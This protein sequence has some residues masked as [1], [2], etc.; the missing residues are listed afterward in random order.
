[1]FC[2]KCGTENPDNARLCQSCSWDLTNISTNAQRSPSTRTLAILSLVL[3]IS[4]IALLILL[5]AINKL[6]GIVGIVLVGPQTA[7]IALVL[8]AIS[9]IKTKKGRSSAI[10]G[11]II[12]ALWLVVLVGT[13]FVYTHPHI[14]RVPG[15]LVRQRVQLHILDAAI[16]LFASE[17]KGYPPSDAMDKDKKPYCGAMKLCEAMMGQDLLG[18]HPDSHFRCDGTND[19]HNPLY[20][21]ATLQAR[22]GPFL[23]VEMSN[24]YQLKDIYKDVWL[25]DRNSYIIC[26]TFT[27]Q[28]HAGKKTG[29][30]ILYYKADK[31]KTK[32]NLENPDDPNNIYNYKDN[33]ALLELGVP[34]D[35]NT[36]HPLFTDPKIFYEV[37]KNYNITTQSRPCRADSY[38]LLSAG[39]D[40][41]YGTKDDIGNFEMRWKPG[42]KGKNK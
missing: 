24:A 36:K 2:P 41:L 23:P 15:R 25:F 5:A 31:S 22:K 6:L 12:S 21:P 14:R 27:K 29:M 18:F 4:S 9:L 32:H 20:G 35:P 11:V 40:G 33:Y 30:P 39:F 19:Y 28:R 17:L 42:Q 10:A 8:G 37:T 13:Y 1:M 34:D 7:I 16:E 38:I 3:S 26:D